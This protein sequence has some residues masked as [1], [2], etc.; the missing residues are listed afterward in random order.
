MVTIID[1]KTRQNQ[2]GETYCALILEGDLE[3]VQSAETGRYYATARRASVSSTFS[4]ETCQRLIGKQMPGTILKQTCDSYEYTVPETGEIIQL[5]HRYV[6]S[7]TD[8]WKRRYSPRRVLYSCSILN[9]G[10]CSKGRLLFL[11]SPVTIRYL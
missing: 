9:A 5:K 4:E 7:P 3:M 10:G 2:S 8:K 11:C 1:Y 6:Y